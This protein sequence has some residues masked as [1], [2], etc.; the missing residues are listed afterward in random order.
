[1]SFRKCLVLIPVFY[2]RYRQARE[3]DG[4]RLVFKSSKESLREKHKLSALE[5]YRRDREEQ[6]KTCGNTTYVM[7]GAPS[8]HIKIVVQ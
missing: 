4:F 8:H 2:Y 3:I 6:Y 7:V 5:Y 1:M